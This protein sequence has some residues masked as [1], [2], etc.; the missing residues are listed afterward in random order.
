MVVSE[1]QIMHGAVDPA[2]YQAPLIIHPNAVETLSG[3]LQGF[4][5]V[6]GRGP[7]IDKVVCILEKGKLPE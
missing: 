1:F 4:K 6:G 3:S 7:Q 2:E 5:P